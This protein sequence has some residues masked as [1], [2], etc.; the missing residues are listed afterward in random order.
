MFILILV[1]SGQGVL[2]DGQEIAVKRLYRSSGQGLAEFKNEIALTAKLQHTNL[3][4]LLG[5]CFEE[6][7]K[8]LLYEF[9]PNKSLDYF[10]F[11]ML[12]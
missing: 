5:F 9:M 12:I 6:G 4:K 3:V 11:G 1:V 7:E 10:L 2:Q 8:N